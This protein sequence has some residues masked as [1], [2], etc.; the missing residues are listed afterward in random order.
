[1]HKFE[2]SLVSIFSNIGLSLFPMK[3]FMVSNM[4]YLMYLISLEFPT[5]SNQCRFPRSPAE[6]GRAGDRGLQ[7][8]RIRHSHVSLIE[9]VIECSIALD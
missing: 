1:M 4:N 3:G 2:H 8:Y 9:P 7:R 5:E 6:R